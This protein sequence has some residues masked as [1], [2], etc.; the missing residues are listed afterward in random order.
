MHDFNVDAMPSEGISQLCG[1]TN[2]MMPVMVRL[3]NS[4]QVNQ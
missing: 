2:Y 1:N 3:I 4:V